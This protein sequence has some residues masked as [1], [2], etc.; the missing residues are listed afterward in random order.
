LP[1]EDKKVFGP[2]L[3][4]QKPDVKNETH[5]QHETINATKVRIER[6]DQNNNRDRYHQ[7]YI[8][9]HQLLRYNERHYQ[10]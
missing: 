3:V 2:P 6:K 7:R 5:N 8:N 9:P 1:Q 10:R 4:N